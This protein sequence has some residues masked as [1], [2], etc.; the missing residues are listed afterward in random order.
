MKTLTE[1]HAALHEM[2]HEV[3]TSLFIDGSVTAAQMKRM[4]DLLDAEKQV[5]PD[6]VYQA[7]VGGHASSFF[8][9]GHI[10]DAMFEVGVKGFGY[11]DTVT[12]A[13]GVATSKMLGDSFTH[14][15][16][17]EH[18]KPAHKA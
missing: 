11:E 17:R 4:R 5:V 8:I 14:F 15:V 9:D 1:R 10:V 12:V 13:N 16:V 6:G 7:S 3:H 2:L 18:R